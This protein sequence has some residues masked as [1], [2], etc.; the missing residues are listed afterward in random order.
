[1]AVKTARGLSYPNRFRGR[2]LSAWS[3]AL[4]VKSMRVYP[5]IKFASE[6]VLSRIGI[7]MSEAMELFLVI[8]D[9]KLP[10]EVIA[11]EDATLEKITSEWMHIYEKRT[12]GKRTRSS[13]G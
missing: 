12:A 2:R 9:E 11:L 10:F 8:V 7:S 1:M 6:L 3:I 5:Q 4:R 13:S